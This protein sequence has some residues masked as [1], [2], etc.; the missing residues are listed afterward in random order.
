VGA[1]S[2]FRSLWEPLYARRRLLVRLAISSSL[3]GFLVWRV[4]IAEALKTLTHVNYVYALPALAVFSLAKLIFAVRWRVM[5]GRLGQ[6][7]VGTLFGTLLVSN[8]AN[9]V[10]PLRLGDVLR[11]QVPAQRHGISRPGLASSVFVTETLL[12]GV[13]FAVLALVGITLLN[14]PSTLNDFAWAMIGAV[15]TGLLLAVFGAHMSLPA[16]WRPGR[17]LGWLP[18][19]ARRAMA[20]VLPPFVEGLAALRHPSMGSRVL[21]LSFT[22]WLLEVLMFWL[23]GLGFGLDLSL[24][25]YLMIVITANMVIALPLAPSNVGPY[26]VAVAEVVAAL[27]VTRSLA[28]GYAIATHLLNILWVSFTGVIAMWALGLRFQDI[29]YLR[30]QATAPLPSPQDSLERT[31]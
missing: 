12:D 21:A 22:G 10:L 13:T 5:L 30:A 7:P 20:D 14:V 4:D 1:V 3:V 28:G 19:R 24:G 26:E 9:N 16:G 2:V 11:V 31:A 27:G 29:F 6:P 15:G 8:M 18:Q 17:W 23:L 25:S